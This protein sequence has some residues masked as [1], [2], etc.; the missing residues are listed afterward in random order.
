MLL[1]MVDRESDVR[2]RVVSIYY[3]AASL[4]SDIVSRGIL[5]ESILAET[6]QAK[7][8]SILYINP[9]TLEQ[10]YEYVDR[11]ANTS[12]SINDLSTQLAILKV[13]TVFIVPKW[14]KNTSYEKKD[15]VRVPSGDIYQCLVTHTSAEATKPTIYPTNWVLLVQ[16]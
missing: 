9:T 1:F 2:A 6:D 16:A 12:E 5:V 14:T 8:D 7:K 11:P 10:W 15:I 13:L 3:D 4:S